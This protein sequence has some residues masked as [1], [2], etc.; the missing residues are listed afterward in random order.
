M[1]D[2]LIQSTS[3]P[4]QSLFS[5][6]IIVISIGLLATPY[7]Y[8][9]IL[10][11]VAIIIFLLLSK[12]PQ[13][14]Y[15]L[16]IFLIPFGA[17]RGL[18]GTYQFIKIHWIIAF[19]LTILIVLQIVVKKTTP[20]NL[21]S[22]LWTWFVI[23]FAISLI[24]ALT[25]DYSLTSFDNLRLLFV[26]FLFVALNL[27]FISNK[28]FC[29][30]LP[31]ILILSIS[32]SSFLSII[33]YLFD[34][35]VFTEGPESLKRGIGGSIDPNNIAFMIVFSLPL[36]VNWFFETRKN[37]I[38]C[39]S[40]ILLA[41]NVSSLILT[42]SRGGA[43]VLMI[44]TSLLCIE[45]K[46]KFKPKYLWSITSL[47][48]ISIA[49]ILIFVPASYWERHKRI[50]KTV[51]DQTV[52]RRI[53]YLYVAWDAFKENPIIGSG[54]GTFRD[55]YA[56]TS[57]ARKYE[58][59]R[60][61]NRR[62][63]HNTY[64]EFLIGTGLIGIIIFFIILWY[65]LRN[66]HIARKTFLMKGNKEMYSITGAYQISFLSLLFFLFMFSDMYHKYLLLSL[67]MSQISL[68][69]SHETKKEEIL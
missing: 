61:S 41:V 24:S 1:R 48:A 35:S 32:V 8:L 63:A 39:F 15:Y 19:W 58:Q 68:R 53:S 28:G 47:L 37:S 40:L 44:T 69:L 51:T 20:A 14:G 36:I 2:L 45:H 18:S 26:A 43:M 17:Y 65:A 38:K 34:T 64:I 12:Y 10:P 56:G 21:R 23:L 7:Y 50:T 67:A 11:G 52:G 22:N 55:I 6:F 13:Y 5:I 9:A 31:L 66:F 16:I 33:G 59:K 42:Y 62:F 46:M 57:F 49:I 25:S 54:P 60:R 4:V 29:T 27:I 3:R 30:T